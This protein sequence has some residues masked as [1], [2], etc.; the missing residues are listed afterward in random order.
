MAIQIPSSQI[1]DQM[2]NQ[3]VKL[4]TIVPE[5]KVFNKKL[6][7]QIQPTG[8]AV[9]SWKVVDLPDGT[10]MIN[11][12]YQVG[13]KLFGITNIGKEYDKISFQV[14]VTLRDYQ[15]I[16]VRQAINMLN[17]EC[18]V[19]FSM[20]MGAGK[21]IMSTF[22]F[23]KIGYKTLILCPWV[24]LSRQ[25]GAEIRS[26][27]N[28]IV[29]VVGEEKEPDR[30]DVA[31]CYYHQTRCKKLEGHR[32]GTLVVDESHKCNNNTGIQA[33]LTFQPAYVIFCSGT[34][35]SIE[36]RMD[37]VTNSVVGMNRVNVKFMTKIHIIKLETGIQPTRELNAQGTL[38]WT[39]LIQSLMYESPDRDRML[40][41]CLKW[42]LYLK[43][44]TLVITEEVNHVKLVTDAVREF[45]PFCDYLSEDRTEYSDSYITI[46]IKHK[47]G[48]GFDA[49]NMATEYNGEAIQCVILMIG[50]KKD[51]LL[52]Q[53][54]GRAFR[55]AQPILIY[56]ADRDKTCSSHYNGLKL[57][58]KQS[59]QEKDGI[60]PTYHVTDIN[61]FDDTIQKVLEN[62][63]QT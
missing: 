43:V 21:S 25:W 48:T 41:H 12:P 46:G 35:D 56:F 45:Y 57:W 27:T 19:M 44:K 22:V 24:W 50:P 7:R 38:N 13:R 47:C 58:E 6:G 63:K 17:S 36:D 32:I 16:A 51:A 61:K 2:Y 42:L 55:H 3:I 53:M 52:K 15:V 5:Q 11:L 10:R 34:P 4:L 31:T 62:L 39:R 8:K 9:K 49:A 26:K 18:C 60:D 37:R 1:D 28:A 23:S 29:W 20:R 40:M 14:N 59:R 30:W 54:V 33:I